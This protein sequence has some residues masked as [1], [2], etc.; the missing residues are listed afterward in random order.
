MSKNANHLPRLRNT[1]LKIT[2]RGYLRQLGCTSALN[3]STAKF[4]LVYDAVIAAREDLK[5]SATVL[6]LVNSRFQNILKFLLK[7]GRD[8]GFF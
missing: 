7:A 2:K 5:G 4:A 1:P 3:K 8:V 6:T